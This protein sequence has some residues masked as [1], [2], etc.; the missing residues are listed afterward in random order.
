MILS[1]DEVAP[2]EAA[3]RGAGKDWA[4]TQAAM[5]AVTEACFPQSH[6]ARLWR[7]NPV[8]R[9][10]RKL[11]PPGQMKAI[12]DFIERQVIALG[13]SMPST[14]GIAAWRATQSLDAPPTAGS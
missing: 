9:Y 11:P 8:W 10:V 5:K 13:L 12:W 4:K 1:A 6:W 2:L 3:L 14:P 7:V